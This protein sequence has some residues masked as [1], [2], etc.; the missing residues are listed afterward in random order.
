MRAER[1]YIDGVWPIAEMKFGCDC[2]CDWDLKR[3][4]RRAVDW[5]ARSRG[6]CVGLEDGWNSDRGRAKL[7]QKS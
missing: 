4:G 6:A 3:G 1:G 5:Q 2:G 7:V